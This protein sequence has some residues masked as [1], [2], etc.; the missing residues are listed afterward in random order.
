MKIINKS[1]L[2][3]IL[4]IVVVLPSCK[5]YLDAKSDKTLV[6]PLAVAD[7][8]GLLDNY[9]YMNTVGSQAGEDASDNYY[10][11]DVKFLALPYDRSGHSYLWQPGIFTG[12]SGNPFGISSRS[13]KLP[14]EMGRIIVT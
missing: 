8:Q 1:I 14:Q 9:S 6:V 7:L 13:D 3:L 4:L 2:K 5:K 11:P 10:L 12:A